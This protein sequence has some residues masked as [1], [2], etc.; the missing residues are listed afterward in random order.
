[1]NARRTLLAAAAM[2]AA[3]LVPRVATAQS[4]FEGVVT[5]QV[6]GGP[7]PQTMKYSIKGDRVRMDMSAQGM[8]MYTVFNATTKTMDMV[9]PMNQ[10]YMEHTVG[11]LQ[12]M[13][14]S[15]A[16]KTDID[17]TGQTETIAGHECE[18]ATVT[19]DG[20][21]TDVCLAKDLGTFVPMS[22]GMGGRGGRG[23][24]GNG[25]GWERHLGRGFPLKVAHDGQVQ[26]VV[27]SIEEK[28]LDDSLFT[29]PD[30]YRKMSMPGRGGGR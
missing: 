12:A 4:S 25:A 19:T 22:G 8:Q 21:T 13:A 16:G 14:D 5:F 7:G 17:W 18:H 10:M 29:V 26:M 27:T 15:A 28:S 3:M 23:R 1:M 9:I 2:A 24:G 30:G 11:D 6:N 20:K